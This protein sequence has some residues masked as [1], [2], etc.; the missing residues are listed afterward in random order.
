LCG[1]GKRFD[2]KLR[3]IEDTPA[4]SARKFLHREI[5][6]KF[7]VRSPKRGGQE[8]PQTLGA[9]HIYWSLVPIEVKRAQQTRDSVKMVSMK[10]SN[11]D[12]MDAAAL[13]GRTHE[14]NLRTLTAVEQKYVA[15]SDESCRR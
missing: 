7:E 6:F 13:F 15:F 8:V 4:I 11:E 5:V 14:L 3:F 2:V 10:V 1:R 9:E 12:G